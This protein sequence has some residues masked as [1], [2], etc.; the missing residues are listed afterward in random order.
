MAKSSGRLLGHV[1]AVSVCFSLSLL[2]LSAI[3]DNVSFRIEYGQRFTPTDTSSLVYHVFRERACFIDGVL[4]GLPPLTQHAL[5][6]DSAL[7]CSDF[8]PPTLGG[9][10]HVVVY[11]CPRI[12]EGSARAWIER[13]LAALEDVAADSGRD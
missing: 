8:K 11:K 9:V 6:R 4:P 7:F 12:L 13:V 10:L 3:C 2:R 5:L 1:V